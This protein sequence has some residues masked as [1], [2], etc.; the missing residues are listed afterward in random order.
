MTIVEAVVRVVVVVI[1]VDR[2]RVMMVRPRIVR[3]PSVVRSVPAPT[4]VEAAAVPAGTIVIGTIV[5]VRPP[6]VVAHVNAYTPACWTVIVPIHV[7][8]VGVVV[9]PAEGNVSVE[10]ADT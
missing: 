5:V 3:I 1:P 4:V 10:P 2:H 8:E 6:P 7:G 9:T